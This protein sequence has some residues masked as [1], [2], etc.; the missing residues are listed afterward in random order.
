MVGDQIES[1]SAEQCAAAIDAELRALPVQNAESRRAIRRKYTQQLQQVEGEH[2]LGVARFL[3]Y[4]YGYRSFAYELIRYHPAAFHSLGKAVLEELGQ[5]INSWW[6][7]D[8]FARILAGPAWLHGHIPDALIH[9]WA[10][11]EDLWW[12]RAALVST[13][14]FNV[15]SHGGQGDVIRTLEVCRM[16]V[17]D[18]ED[19]VVKGM[20]WALRELVIHDPDAVSAFLVEHEDMLGARVKRE[21]RNKLM[22]GLKNPKR[23]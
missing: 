7:V 14:A 4:D 1:L 9:R 21:V 5:G 19:M 11:S 17:A 6:A 12:R 10:R 20:S 15:R 23:K 22:T 16:L 2:M 8:S 3:I 13:V 18:H